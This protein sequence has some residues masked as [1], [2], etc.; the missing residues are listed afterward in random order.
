MELDER[1]AH[2]VARLTAEK[3]DDLDLLI[4]SLPT[5]I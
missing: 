2:C 1:E 4:E 5:K 3:N